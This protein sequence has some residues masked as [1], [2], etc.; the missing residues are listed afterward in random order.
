MK[1]GELLTLRI[2]KL[3][4]GGKGLGRVD[5]FVIFVNRALPGQL[6]RIQLAKKKTNYAE[7]EVVEILERSPLEVPP[8][9]SSFGRCGGCLWQNLSYEAQLSYKEE[10]VKESFLHLAKIQ[11]FEILPILPSPKTISYRNKAEFT[12]GRTEE[13]NLSLGFHTL[14]RYDKVEDVSQCCLIGQTGNEILRAIK[15]YFSAKGTE[16][17]H[18]R[19]HRGFLRHLVLREGKRTGE[20]MVNL[21]TKNGSLD[22]EELVGML[23]EVAKESLASVL[24]TIND[25]LGDAVKWD[26]F[27]SIF[28][29][30]FITERL[31][32]LDFKISPFSFFQPNTEAAEVLCERIMDFANLQGDEKILDLYSGIGTMGLVLSR[33]AKKVYGVEMLY[34]SVEDAKENARINGIKNVEFYQADV[35]DFLKG[36]LDREYFPLI[37]LDP[38]RSGMTKE[39]LRRTLAMG[40]RKI[41]YVSCNPSTMARDIRYFVE[42]GYKLK[43]VQ[44]ID[45]FPH[46]PHIEVIA[47]VMKY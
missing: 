40:A 18:H 10:Q 1:R 27:N 17:Y 2:E 19:S 24:W 14:G 38:P 47:E 23:K 4:Y 30:E 16:P 20:V 6:I 43:R 11:N 12:F 5:N 32:D 44:P 45:L 15:E 39:A 26:Y 9:C 22:K 46:T 29:N 33:K 8:L 35:A 41:I 13:G 25:S 36:I 31:L 34:H 3:A 7:G 21:V 42:G 28:G 37:L